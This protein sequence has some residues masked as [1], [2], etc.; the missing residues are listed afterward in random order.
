MWTRSSERWEDKPGNFDTLN[1][2][3]LYDSNDKYG[4][5]T[6]RSPTIA[7]LPEA[8]NCMIPYTL[9]VRS[10]MGYTDAAMH[11]FLDDYRFELVWHKP[12]MTL[13]RVKKAWLVL[14]PD[15]SLYANY[16][17]AAQIWNTYRNRW[18]GAFWQSHGLVVVPTVTWSTPESYEFCFNGIEYGSPVAVSTQGIR[19]NA[20][21]NTKFADG[22]SEMINRLNPRFVM[23]YGKLSDDL[24]A[25]FPDSEVKCYPTYWENLRKA[26]AAGKSQDFYEGDPSAHTPTTESNL[27]SL[28]T[29]I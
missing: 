4:I 13:S 12:I 20:E 8:P 1:V 26:R 6:L 17:L 10:E 21:A 16:P 24:K 27:L 9:R 14:T 11:F 29:S 18:C 3:E 28:D 7:E 2:R 5:P 25:K 15:F 19:T 23:C 22:Y